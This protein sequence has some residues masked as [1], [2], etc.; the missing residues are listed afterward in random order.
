M[1][2]LRKL[3]TPR[4][5]LNLWRIDVALIGIFVLTAII[6]NP[7]VIVSSQSLNVETPSKFK[8]FSTPV[9]PLPIKNDSAIIRSKL[10]SFNLKIDQIPEGTKASDKVTGVILNNRKILKS[11]TKILENTLSKLRYDS[12]IIAESKIIQ[13]IPSG[14]SVKLEANLNMP[15]VKVDS[16]THKRSWI[17]KIFGFK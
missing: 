13:P 15:E 5:G 10:D 8:R 16:C 7:R 9:L 1:N 11:Q 17:K 12:L 6:G 3:T 4:K 2:Y 14:D